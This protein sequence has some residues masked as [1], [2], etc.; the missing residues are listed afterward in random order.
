M[1]KKNKIFIE[2]KANADCENL[3]DC[4]KKVKEIHDNGNTFQV[5]CEQLE[6]L[7]YKYHTEY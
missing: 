2:K 1:T 3:T 6:E 5:I 7:G 4:A